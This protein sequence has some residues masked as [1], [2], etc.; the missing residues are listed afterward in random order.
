MGIAQTAAETMLGKVNSMTTQGLPASLRK[1]LCMIPSSMATSSP[2]VSLAP[3]IPKSV[4]DEIRRDNL[5][6]AELDEVEGLLGLA[7]AS[8]RLKPVMTEVR[9]AVMVA[10]VKGFTQLTEILSKR[11]QSC[12]G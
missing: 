12:R 1:M 11:G 10:D 4:I 5:R 3:F 2:L 6:Y 9:A 7:A 8:R